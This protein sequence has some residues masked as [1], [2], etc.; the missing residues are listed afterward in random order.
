M[1]SFLLTNFLLPIRSPPVA[2]VNTKITWLIKYILTELLR[3]K[4]N[5]WQSSTRSRINPI[6]LVV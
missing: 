1:P 5:V 4:K 2:A 6:Y 3:N